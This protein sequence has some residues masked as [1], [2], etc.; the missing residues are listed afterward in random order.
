M[1]NSILTFLSITMISFSVFANSGNSGNAMTFVI[2]SFG[3]SSCEM[4]L[5]NAQALIF[6]PEELILNSLLIE[7]IL[8]QLQERGFE[9]VTVQNSELTLGICYTHPQVSKIKVVDIFLTVR[10]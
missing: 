2:S 4:A 6:K 8:P 10:N 9:A 1:K 7:E 5:K 3:G